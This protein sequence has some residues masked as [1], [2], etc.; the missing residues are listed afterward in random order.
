MHLVVVPEDVC[1][2]EPRP[3]RSCYLG[4]QGSLEAGDP[5]KGFW[6]SAC[7]A[8]EFPLELPHPYRTLISKISYF[9]RA[10][11]AKNVLCGGHNGASRSRAGCAIHE[12]LLCDQDTLLE[13][14][15]FS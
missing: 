13:G 10:V 1:D 8:A 9:H 7:L 2:I 5:G 12:K 4:I 11:A 15:S 14:R 6:R 3:T